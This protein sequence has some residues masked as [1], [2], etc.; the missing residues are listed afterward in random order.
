MKENRSLH[1][2]VQ[3]MC[4][5]YA[6]TDPLEEMARMAG[7]KDDLQESAVK[8]LALAILHGINSHAEEIE[9]RR[10]EDGG[11][12]VKA[13]YRTGELPAPD[14]SI[15]EAVIETVRQITHIEEDKGKLPFSVGIRDSSV[16]LEIKIK[17]RGGKQKF[18]LKFK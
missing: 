5:C 9:L 11:V 7:E 13:Q 1:L 14:K 17:A 4:D 10:S 12:R 3:E 8:W 18:K 2:R 6:T 16:D 15:A